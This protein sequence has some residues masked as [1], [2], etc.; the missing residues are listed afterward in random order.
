MQ[1]PLHCSSATAWGLDLR[2]IQ[3]KYIAKPAEC[4]KSWSVKRLYASC[5]RAAVM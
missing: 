2:K 5:I 3:T 4:I 1:S